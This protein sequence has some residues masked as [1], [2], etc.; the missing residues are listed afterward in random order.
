MLKWC[1]CLTDD[2]IIPQISDDLYILHI[3][4][5]LLGQRIKILHLGRAFFVFLHDRPFP[6]K[7]GQIE[8]KRILQRKLAARHQIQRPTATRPGPRIFFDHA[9]EYC[10]QAR[11]VWLTRSFASFYPLRQTPC[12]RGIDAF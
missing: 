5:Y 9:Q 10:V 7:A 1:I 6:I 4:H 3:R 8:A 12:Q 2:L 11:N